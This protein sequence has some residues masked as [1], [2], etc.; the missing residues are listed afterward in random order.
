MTWVIYNLHGFA[1]MHIKGKL[2]H[3]L[4]GNSFFFFFFIIL[5]S[6]KARLMIV[7]QR[8]IR[9]ILNRPKLIEHT[10]R[11]LFSCF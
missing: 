5:Y 10:M 9:N 1:T 3:N 8:T 11:Q 7:R 4:C 2:A 6:V